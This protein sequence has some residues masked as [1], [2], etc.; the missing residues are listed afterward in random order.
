MVN[1]FEEDWALAQRAI[2]YQDNIY[3]DVFPVANIVRYNRDD[4][5]ILDIKYHIEV[6]IELRNGIKLLGQEK[7]LRACF[8]KYNTF[9]IEFYQNRRIK[10]PGEFFNIG[11]QFYLHGYWNDKGDGFCKWYMVKLFDFLAHLKKID[12]TELEART[13]PSTS[14]ANFFYINY[15]DIPNEFIYARG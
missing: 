2:P 1:K 6:E 10:E 11:A 4:E 12:I 9:T 5:I 3:R 15:N 13:R 14:N 8:A 7:A